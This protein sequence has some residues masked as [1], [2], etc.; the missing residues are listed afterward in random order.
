MRQKMQMQ[1]GGLSI[2]EM[3]DAAEVSR[4]SFYR[5]WR[6]REPKQEQVAIGDAIQRLALKNRYY[7]YRRIGRLLKREGWG[8]NHKRVLRVMR[9]DNL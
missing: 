3:C 4:A 5:S 6:K 2:R 9:E 8:V 7:G 1:G